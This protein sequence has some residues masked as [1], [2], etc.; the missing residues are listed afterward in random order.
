[1]HKNQILLML[2]IYSVGQSGIF[3]LPSNLSAQKTD[4][5]VSV[6]REIVKNMVKLPGGSFTM[7]D[8][9]GESHEKPARR[10]AVGPFLISKYE[11]TQRQY[12]I[13]MGH[14]PS[15]FKGNSK[16]PVEMVTWQ[17]CKEF[18]KRLNQLEGK[19]LFRLPTEKEWEYACRAGTT[20]F[21][22]FGTVH[23]YEVKPLGEYAWHQ[24]N[25]GNKTHPVGQRKPNPWGLFDMHGNVWE[26]CE[27]SYGY[28]QGVVPIIRG[29]AYNE[30]AAQLESA[31]RGYMD[32][33]MRKTNVGLRL[34]RTNQ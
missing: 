7:G 10:V 19:E 17:D 11:V 33:K 5:Q 31:R 18:V 27:G 14:N 24:G 9:L 1:M 21:F 25:S 32:A 34:V 22:Y 30:Y 6:L 16:L 28:P 20:T 26:W 12:E 8:D 2:L 4:E 23:G 13:I 3:F 29:G 15:Y